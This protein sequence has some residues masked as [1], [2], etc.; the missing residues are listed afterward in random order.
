MYLL[1]TQWRWGCLWKVRELDRGTICRLANT[2]QHN[3]GDGEVSH[4]VGSRDCHEMG[5]LFFSSEFKDG[6]GWEGND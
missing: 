3:C 4:T 5:V 6:R 2:A 1:C